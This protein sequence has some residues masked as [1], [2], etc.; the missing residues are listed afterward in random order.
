MPRKRRTDKRRQEVTDEHESW[1]HGDDSASGFVKYE[2][3][4]ALAA[5]W[6]AHSERIVEDH[7]ADFPGTR[8]A[9][10]WQHDAPR[11]PIGTYPGCYFDGKLPAP[12][13]RLG[14]IG[15]PASDVLAYVPTFAYGIPTIWITKRDVM[16]F[17]GTA[18]DVHGNPVGGELRP[19]KGVAIDPD[20]PPTFEPQATYL[21]RLGLFLAGEERRLKKGDWEAERI[22]RTALRNEE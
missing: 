2:P 15:T 9:R 18:V 21:K 22:S 13:K 17:S 10:W 12:R 3:A 11:I 5:L 8:P 1:L 6:A 16:Y 4:E 14:G 20:D 7:V 19:F